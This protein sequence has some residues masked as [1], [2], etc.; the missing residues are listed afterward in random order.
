MLDAFNVDRTN[1]SRSLTEIRNF[2]AELCS[3]IQSLVRH[4]QLRGSLANTEF[5]ALTLLEY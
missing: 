2:S 3:V 1:L 4:P 5:M